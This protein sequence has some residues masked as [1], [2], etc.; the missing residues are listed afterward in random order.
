MDWETGVQSQVES[1][2]RLK[3]IIL[4]ATLLYT[5]HYKV[6]IKDKVEQ[7]RECSSVHFGVVAIENGAFGSPSTK[8]VNFTLLTNNYNQC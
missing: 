2:Q 3:I 7:S 4:D 1:Y 6:R 8:V 5:Q